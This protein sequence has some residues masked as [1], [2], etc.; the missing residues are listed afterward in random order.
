MTRLTS[1]ALGISLALVSIGLAHADST[2]GGAWKLTVGVND[3]PCTM[4][5]SPDESG[6]AG[7]IASGTDCPSGLYSVATWKAVGTGIQLY[8][9]SGELVASLKPKGDTFV[10]MRFADGR[11]LA[12]SR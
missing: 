2:I 4:T 5:F 7:P 12:L 9:G 8:S 6:A 1:L 10:G 3:A 11:K